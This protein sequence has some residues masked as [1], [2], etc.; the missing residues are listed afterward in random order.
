ML[1][2]VWSQFSQHSEELWSTAAAILLLYRLVLNQEHLLTPFWCEF[3]KTRQ[4]FCKYFKRIQFIFALE[5]NFFFSLIFAYSP[6]QSVIISSIPSYHNHQ[7]HTNLHLHL[8]IALPFTESAKMRD[9]T[10]K[11][12]KNLCSTWED[13]ELKYFW[14]PQFPIYSQIAPFQNDDRITSWSKHIFILYKYIH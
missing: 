9:H 6:V 11:K 7:Y 5:F 3:E 4:L 8:A 2:V 10:Y 14:R 12:K 1:I 13:T